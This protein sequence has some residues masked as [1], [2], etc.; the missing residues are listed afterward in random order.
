MADKQNITDVKLTEKCR[1]FF[2]FFP[3]QLKFLSIYFLIIPGLLFTPANLSKNKT[4]FIKPPV[5]KVSLK[6]KVA[7]INREKGIQCVSTE[8]KE[9]TVR[10][11]HNNAF[12]TIINQAANQ[13][14]IDPALIKAIIMAES[15]YNPNALSKKGAM[16]LM[17]LMPNT[18]KWLGVEDSF[19]PE[20]NI[21]GGVKYFKYLLKKFDGNI[22]LALAAYNA[23]SKYVRKYHGIPPFQATRYYI[24]KVFQYYNF[25]KNQT[26]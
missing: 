7:T 5:I 8:K 26:V 17:Q 24:T 22:K 15:G 6:E 13:Y 25:Y 10:H 12:D 9:I 21:N 23:G 4:T 1:L 2:L 20:H 16:G 14:Q 11:K 19:N 3:K 18:A